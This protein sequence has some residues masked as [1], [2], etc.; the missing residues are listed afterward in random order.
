MP[1]DLWRAPGSSVAGLDPGVVGDRPVPHLLAA[2]FTPTP[3]ASLPKHWEGRIVSL[4]APARHPHAHHTPARP[5]TGKNETS[6]CRRWSY[7]CFL[8]ASQAYFS[9][10]SPPW[11]SFSLSSLP[12]FSQN[13]P[14]VRF[15]SPG[16]LRGCS[17][18]QA[19][20]APLA[21]GY[22]DDPCALTK[23]LASELA[24]NVAEEK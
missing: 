18:P 4:L 16:R 21:H 2:L 5:S 15:I 19:H 6:H 11:L 3:H 8:L 22:H 13:V 9:F 12:L 17:P 1:V 23:R 24:K 7:T 10:S 14:L 20:P